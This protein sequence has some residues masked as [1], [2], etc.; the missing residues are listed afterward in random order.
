LDRLLQSLRGKVTLVQAARSAWAVQWA[1]A[2][3]LPWE[4]ASTPI[5]L[6]KPDI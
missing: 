3:P 2:V 6:P 4:Q 5:L 1:R